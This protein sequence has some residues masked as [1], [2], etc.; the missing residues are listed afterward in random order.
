MFDRSHAPLAAAI[1]IAALA[2]TMLSTGAVRAE[3]SCQHGKLHLAEAAKAWDEQTG[4]DKR[5]FPPDRLVDYLHMKLEM[6][7]PD[8]ET[9]RFTAVETLRLAPIGEPTTSIELDA[10][11]LDVSSARVNGQPVEFFVGDE[12]VT[13]RFDPPLELGREYEVVFE[14]VCERPYAGMTF[15]PSATDMDGYTAEVHT[16]GQTVT[17]RHWFISHDSPNE[18]LTS[19]LIVDV[20]AG[21]AVSGNGRLVGQL[22]NDGRSVWHWLQDK[23]HVSYLVSLVIG[24]F[25]RVELDHPRVPM[26]VWVPRGLGSQVEQSYGNT[27]EMLDLFERRFGLPYPW[28][29]YDQL[30]VKNFGAGGMENTSATTMYPSAIFDEAALLDGDLDGL[31]A[32]ELAHQWT[33]D[34]I[35]CKEW[36][37]IW[38]NEGF[39]T[40]GSALWFE[41]RDGQDG[42]LNSI[43]R[44]MGVARRD[45]T[46]GTVPMV[47]GVYD[48]AWETFRRA[49]NPYP[50]GSSILHMLRRM[51][52]E[53]V[54]W[55]GI[56]LYMK[57]HALGVVET[58][59]LRYAME[60]VSGRGLEWFFEQWCFRPG[61][62][63]LDV[64][65][66]YDGA[67]R[68]LLVDVIQA[69]QIDERTP[70]FR[71]ELP[72]HVRTANGVE[73]YTIDVTET[74]TSFRTTLDGVPEIVAIDPWLHVL[75]TMEV[76]KA[77]RLWKAQAEGGPTLPARHRAIDALGESDTP[78]RRAILSRIV[79]DETLHHSIRN[80]AVAALRGFGSDE[81]KAEMVAILDGE[82]AEAKVRVNV[83][84]A[85][86]DHDADAVAERLAEIA[87]G[88]ISYKTRVAAIN[89]L[90][91]LEAKDHADT[92]AELVHYPSQHDDVRSAALNTLADFDDPRGLDLALQY[93]AFGYMDRARARAIPVIGKLADHDKDR[94]VEALL[95][96]LDDPCRRPARAAG[97]ALSRL[98]DER[99]IAPLEAMAETHADPDRRERAEGWLERVRENVKKAEKDDE[100]AVA[101]SG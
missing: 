72:I 42:Y 78:D 47:S 39:A 14:Y 69:Q 84:A 15:T 74:E 75:C 28:A 87:S 2:V 86:A 64:T 19:E 27:G 66:D 18:R 89:G 57:R 98:D 51:L 3:E 11:G 55:D 16:Q 1:T 76:D 24:D 97:D 4:R 49:G 99:A 95:G 73:T 58:S 21:Y 35:T 32:H 65:V 44:S 29:R 5:N 38:L 53:Q 45:R 92:I 60:E 52:G 34:L 22:T 88:D 31:I 40:Y 59:D 17:N 90:A 33:G 26:T 83:V 36:A 13:L 43:R 100:D 30:V 68:E 9:A 56:Q 41:Q 62:P 80:A 67:K 91:K 7:F 85:L 63:S 93:A 71:L 94:A 23:P 48:K 79:R 10:I 82:V 46:T 6:R 20:P 37:H 61:C 96:Y 8:L 77:E 70:A 25:D 50:K 54:F 12:T 81:A 101:S